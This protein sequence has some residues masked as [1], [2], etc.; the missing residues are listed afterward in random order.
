[1]NNGLCY[2]LSYTHFCNCSIGYEGYNCEIEVNAC[3][4][5]P[6]QNNAT[7]INHHTN[8][9]CICIENYSGR[10]CQYFN[11]DIVTDII[12]TT[13]SSS[14]LATNVMTT[15]ELAVVSAV[16]ASMLSALVLVIFFVILIVLCIYLTLIK[17]S[18]SKSSSG[19]ND[20]ATEEIVMSRN[21]VYDAFNLSPISEERSFSFDG[22]AG[23]ASN[24]I[25]TESPP[26]YDRVQNLP[27]DHDVTTSDTEDDYL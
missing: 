23:P 11:G 26:I 9:S 15:S 2:S 22:P 7:C 27:K 3:L 6:C 5:N 25:N 10:Y 1:M 17:K 8:F 16:I 20:K 14:L 18:I 24:L 21:D 13:V 4:P 19:S 12:T